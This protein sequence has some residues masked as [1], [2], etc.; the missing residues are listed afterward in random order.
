MRFN[1]ISHEL[2]LNRLCS[3]TEMIQQNH[4]R[5]KTFEKSASVKVLNIKPIKFYLG[6]Y[7]N[8][9]ELIKPSAINIE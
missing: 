2:K 8:V 4:V 3:F 7:K 6:T 9:V 1:T 5:K